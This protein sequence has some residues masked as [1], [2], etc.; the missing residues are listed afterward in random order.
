MNPYICKCLSAQCSIRLLGEC[1][2]CTTTTPTSTT[3]KTLITTTTTTLVVSVCV[4]VCL[5]MALIF[6]KVFH[7]I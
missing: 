6:Y 1:L 5:N 4:C 7:F 3:P 2:D